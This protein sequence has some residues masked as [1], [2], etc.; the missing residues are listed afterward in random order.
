MP[1]ITKVTVSASSSFNHPHEQFANFKPFVSLEA[2]LADGDDYYRV[3][4]EL[5][6][7][8]E[9]LVQSHKE[10]IL[11]DIALDRKI[12]EIR[13]DLAY[14]QREQHQNLDR[15]ADIGRLEKQLADLL[16]EQSTQHMM[17]QSSIIDEISADD[18]DL[19]ELTNIADA[20]APKSHDFGYLEPPEDIAF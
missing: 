16:D 19:E 2:E 12:K 14:A 3:V 6:D 11:E 18:D 4:K 1:N 17:T 13:S 15:T 7:R 8:A 5:Q 10:S 9:T 20:E